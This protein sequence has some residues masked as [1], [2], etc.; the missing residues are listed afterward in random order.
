MHC[1]KDASTCRQP[2]GPMPVTHGRRWG[3]PDTAAATPGTCRNNRA[4]R[5]GSC[6]GRSLYSPVPPS[7]A[8][9]SRPA[10]RPAMRCLNAPLTSPQQRQRRRRALPY[11][12]QQQL[13][14]QRVPA[15]TLI[16]GSYVG[17]QVEHVR[18]LSR[19]HIS[20]AQPATA[21]VEDGHHLR[22]DHHV[23]PGCSS[24]EEFRA[25]PPLLP[26]GP[27]WHHTA[28]ARRSARQG[29]PGLTL[30]LQHRSGSELLPR[31]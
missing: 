16:P 8:A 18:P 10:A 29:L 24:C 21:S 1:G 25:L 31:W 20:T 5:A 19:D 23:S 11:A 17:S 14:A 30:T 15:Q 27:G 28:A 3:R 26:N 4:R 22:H 6:T 7:A 13:P 12:L 2:A 9:A